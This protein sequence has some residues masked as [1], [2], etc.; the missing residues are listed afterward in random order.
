MSG[1][2]ISNL[3]DHIGYWL[4]CLSNQVHN[5]F[6]DKLSKYGISVASW[7]VLRILYDNNNLDLS[8]AAQLV[9]VDKSI[10]S[11]MIDRLVNRNLVCRSEGKN[12]RSYSLTLT[13]EARELIPNLASLADENDKKFFKYLSH[14]QRQDLLAMIRKL[15][16]ANNLDQSKHSRNALD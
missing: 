1:T 9:G 15:L 4:R 14:D 2:P 10:L 13:K 16:K 6:A 7:T 8:C 12:R 3:E 11:R 5:S